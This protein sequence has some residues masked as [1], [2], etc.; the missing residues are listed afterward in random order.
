MKAYL[1]NVQDKKGKSP[2]NDSKLRLTIG[3]IVKNEEKTLEK[4]LKSLAPL[5]QAVPSELIITDTGSTDRTVEI[6][7]KY[8]ENL[9]YF[10]WCDDFSAARNTGLKAARGEWFMFIDGDE[11]FEDVTEIIDFFNRGECSR[12]GSASYKKR[13]YHDQEGKTYTDFNAIRI[14]KRYDGI[15]FSNIVHEFIY[16]LEPTKFL[17]A[18]VHHFGY[19]YHNQEDLMK[20]FQ[21]NRKLLEKALKV[22][23]ND[24]RSLFHLA[25][26][27]SNV[28]NYEKVIECS[29]KGLCIEKK[30]PDRMYQLSLQHALLTG[31]FYSGAYQKVL[32]TLEEFLVSGKR[33]EIDFLDFYFCA[34]VSAFKLKQFQKAIQFGQK[35]LDT[36]KKY[37]EHKLDMGRL[38]YVGLFFIEPGYKEEVNLMIGQSRKAVELATLLKK[39]IETLIACGKLHEA[40]VATAQLAVLFPHDEDACQ[41]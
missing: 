22:N 6:A 28:K 26:E 1:R 38:L 10:D 32:D 37:Q 9:I 3:M 25:Q 7:K 39:Q 16:G 23:P 21:R 40:G 34:E 31:Y 14:F 4:C 18:Y 30:Y 29:K 11:W 24:I 5:L 35:Y 20:K 12:Y 41:S 2:F 36:Y 17:Q 27:Y 19:I 13:N 8:T 33:E 15:H